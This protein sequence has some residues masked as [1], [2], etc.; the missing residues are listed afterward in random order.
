MSNVQTLIETLPALAGIK[1]DRQSREFIDVLVK[2]HAFERDG[3]L[4]ISGE[5][6]DNACDYYG[7][8]RGESLWINP[9][10]EQWA[11]DNGGY[12]EWQNAGCIVF[13]N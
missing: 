6:G 3:I 10:L 9:A 5:H 11:K 4:H 7:E 1:W 8:H 2:P 12:F 13:N